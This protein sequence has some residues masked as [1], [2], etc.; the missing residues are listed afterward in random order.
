MA[1]FLSLGVA[2]LVLSPGQAFAQA[3]E[4]SQTLSIPQ[5]R[6]I[7]R[8]AIQTGNIA[9][10]DQISSALLQRDPDDAEA[11]L[12][13]A[14]S[15]RSAGALDV[16]EDAAAAAYRASNNPALQFDAAIMVA[17]LKARKEQFTRAE[18][19]LR[20]ADNVAPDERR[21]EIAARAFRNVSRLNPLSIQ[22]RFTARPSNNVNNGAETLEIELGGLPF[23]I[24]PSGQQL[25]GYEASAGLSLAYRLSENETQKTEALAELYFR[26]IWLDSRA[27]ELVP[28]ASGSDFDYGVVIAGVRHQRLIWPE[29]GTSEFT[30]LLGNSWYGGEELARWGELQLRQTVRTSN[31]QQ[32]RFGAT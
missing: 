28:T 31:V 6:A 19:W 17:D 24:D 20:R 2:L 29:L 16:A 11:L 7:A 18:L 14:L 5:A 13:R 9:L 23:S 32:L 21:K 12:I 30:G 3:S 26:K 8:Q 4:N 15:A 1:A 27:K 10:A 22:L 25:G